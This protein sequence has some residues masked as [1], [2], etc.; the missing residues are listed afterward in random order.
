MNKEH[1]IMIC[2]GVTV[3]DNYIRLTNKPK[4]NGIELCG[5]KTSTQ[6][7][8]L[9][10]QIGEYSEIDLATAGNDS[11]MLVF[12]QAGQPSKVRVGEISPGWLPSAHDPA[13]YFPS[14]TVLQFL[15]IDTKKRPD[16][17]IWPAPAVLL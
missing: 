5:N 9:S 6:L 16:L 15:R 1:G 7:N 2:P 8:L 17:S 10:N 3:S 4:I 12:P 14:R 11:Y 13:T